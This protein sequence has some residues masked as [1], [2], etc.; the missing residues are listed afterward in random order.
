M[1]LETG[2]YISDFNISNPAHT[3]SVS[4]ADSHLR[5]IKSA[6]KASFPNVTGAVASTNAQLD[7]AA[8][9]VVLGTVPA[10]FKDGTATVPGLAFVS[11]PNTGIYQ[12]APNQLTVT[13][14]GSPVASFNTGGMSLAGLISTTGSIS[15]GGAYLGGTGQLCMVGE[16]RM[17]MS[18]AIPSG[19]IV[20]NGQAISRAAY[21]ILFNNIWGTSFG[22]GD[23]FSTFNVPDLRDYVPVGA[24]LSV[25]GVGQKVGSQ[26]HTLSVGELPAHSHTTSV[27]IGGTTGTESA[28]HTHGPGTGA[29]SFF[30]GSG[31]TS[32][33]L[34]VGGSIATSN[35]GATSTES[36]AHTHSWSGS[37][38]FGSDSGTGGGAAHSIIQQSIGLNFITLL[39]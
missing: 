31:T 27:S 21:P 10:L 3:D 24:N 14:N 12:S 4:A 8:N 2:T 23:G 26:T 6:V 17:W 29:G 16:I 22:A 13:A 35:V 1:G 7:A 19:F 30:G 38:N 32:F 11:H 34:A 25:A 5:W 39:G 33:V 37:G 18:N 28:N 15:A 36:A 9:A 20:L